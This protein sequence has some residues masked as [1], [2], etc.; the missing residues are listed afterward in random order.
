MQVIVDL[1]LRGGLS[2]SQCPK[3]GLEMLI[4]SKWLLDEIDADGQV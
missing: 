2:L 3:G 4:Y 1:N